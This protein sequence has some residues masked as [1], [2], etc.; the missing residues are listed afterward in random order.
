MFKRKPLS[1]AVAAA[2]GLTSSAFTTSVSAQG[3]EEERMI[4]E[5]VVTGSRI[6]STVQ[7]TIRPVTITSRIDIEFSGVESVADVLRSSAF[8]SYGSFRERS[9]NAFGQIA[10]LDLRGLGEDRSAILVN[11]RRVPG[12]PLTGSAAVDINSIPLSAVD[13]VETLTDSASAIYGADA[14]GG[15]VNIIMRDEFDGAELEIGGDRPSRLG[16]D[17]DH[18]NFT[19]G[20]S[21]DRANIIFSGE[22][23]KR[24]PVFDADREYSRASVTPSADDGVALLSIET[25]GVSAGGNTG[26]K[27]DFSEAF[28][29]TPDN[30]VQGCDENVYA[31]IRNPFGVQG[32]GCGYAYAN[33]S[34][35]TG[36]LERQSTFL[37][38]TYEI[39]EGHEAYVE[40]RFSKTQSFGRYAPAVGFFRISEDNPLNP[41]GHKQAG[42]GNGVPINAFHRFVAHGNRDD[43]YE[44]IETDTVVGM[45]GTL[46]FGN[47]DINY[48]IFARAYQYRATSEGDTYIL[49]SELERLVEDA[50]YDFINPLSQDPTHLSAVQRSSATLFRDINTDYT[51]FGV[52]LDGFAFDLPAG[53][54]GWAVG[55]EQAREA[56]KDQY[57]NFREAGN[58]IGSAGNSSAGKRNRW[59]V[60]GEMNFP[61]MDEMDI[62]VAARYDD[63]S[64]F[65]DNFSPQ[66]AIRYQPHEQIVLRASVGSGFKAPNLGDI[67]QELSQSFEDAT[68]F[69]RCA[70]QGTAPADCQSFQYEEYTGGNPDLKAEE[71]ESINIGVVI[72]PTDNFTLA[73]DWFEI[74]L[75]DAVSTLNLNTVLA[76]ERFGILPSGVIV[77]RGP[78]VDG[79]R[80]AITNCVGG[81]RAP[82]CGIINVFANL[83][84]LEVQGYD[85]RASYDLATDTAGNYSFRFEFS[86][87]EQN[88]WQSTQVAPEINRTGGVSFPEFR[89]N[90]NLR[91][92]MEDWTVNYKYHYVDTHEGGVNKYDNWHSMDLSVFWHAPWEGEISFGAKNI[93]DRDPSVNQAA[94]GWD[95]NISLPLYDVNGRTPFVAYKHFF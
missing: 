85:I 8:N 5:V 2:V 18:F 29:L 14:I 33:I 71:S 20:A 27:T 6:R 94:T 66:I 28:P 41:F 68:D 43:E 67:G 7:D 64:D 61:V 54:V 23:F 80:G 32:E 25:V 82:N 40:H 58:V 91:W 53:P 57:D 81:V 48:D 92:T 86:S 1:I 78:T 72:S 37:D 46:P 93:T 70:D 89:Y 11:G 77:N 76:F 59:A 19:F 10:L 79:V 51:N 63:Y 74:Q 73:V 34:M 13:R 56:Y 42:E 60:F 21:S 90:A 69:A 49:Q 35:M 88:L 62:H 75:D 95:N 50:E 4:E 17:S 83:S 30:S 36:G 22:W 16:A 39:T 44:R 84:S 47:N 24:H 31:K 12:N 65:G 55:A 15:V 3:G 38:G 52:A 45:S 9:G 26:F 87:V